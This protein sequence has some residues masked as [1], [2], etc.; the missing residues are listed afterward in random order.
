MTGNS[1]RSITAEAILNHF[2]GANFR[3]YS[4][5]SR[6][7]G[8]V[9]PQ[10]LALLTRLRIPVRGLRSKSWREFAGEGASPLDFVITV[11]DRA[12]AE[13]CRVW[14]GQP[15]TA[16]WGVADPAQANGNDLEIT[17]AFREAYRILEVRTRLFISLPL[18]AL[19]NLSLAQAVRDI[20]TAQ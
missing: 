11:C 9:N 12:A 13:N 19:D 15:L 5:G 3:A 18:E 14:P 17:N 2:G 4:A 10:A 7:V 16:Q 6:P 20:G 8:H 1:A